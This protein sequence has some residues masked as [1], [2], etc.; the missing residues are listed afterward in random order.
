MGKL[1]R[2]NG[3]DK[4]SE[5]VF[6]TVHY[7]DGT[8]EDVKCGVLFTL[9]DNDTMD[10]HIGVD[11][12]YQLFGVRLCLEDC[13]RKLGLMEMYRKYLENMGKEDEA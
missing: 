3:N 11:K 13:I 10:V 5:N 12:G 6:F 9:N 8:S 1:T 4:P 7:A 2:W